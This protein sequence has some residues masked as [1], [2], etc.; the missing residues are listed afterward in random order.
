MCKNCK[1]LKYNLDHQKRR[2]TVSPSRKIARQKPS[3]SF[4]LKYLSPA[5]VAQ[6]KKATQRERSADKAKLARVAELDVSLDEDQS[7]E[8]T[9]TMKHIEEA[10]QDELEKIFK[11]ADEHSVGESIRAA[12]ESNRQSTKQKF[13]KDQQINSQCVV[14]FAIELLLFF[15]AENGCRNNRWNLIT[16]RIGMV[17]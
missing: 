7:D 5:S 17:I 6:R 2:S 12:W 9:N 16:I 13:F 14:E 8:L 10:N 15:F 1:H 4:K 3:S 11:E